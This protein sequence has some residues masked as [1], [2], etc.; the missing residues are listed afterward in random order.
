MTIHNDQMQ[1]VQKMQS[2]ISSDSFIKYSCSKNDS[3]LKDFTMVK[4]AA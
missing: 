1:F 4:Y 3:S 2:L